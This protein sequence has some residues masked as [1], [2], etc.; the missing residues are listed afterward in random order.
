MTVSYRDVQRLTARDLVE[1][2][3]GAGIEDGV[4]H[5]AQ[6]L[7]AGATWDQVRKVVGGAS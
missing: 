4:P 6:R 1:S 7:T 2:H 3:P 5:N